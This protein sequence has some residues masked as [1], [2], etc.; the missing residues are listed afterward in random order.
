MKRSLLVTVSLVLLALGGYANGFLP[1]VPS[2]NTESAEVNAAVGD[3]MCVK[4]TR[5]VT[6]MASTLNEARLGALAA[7]SQQC[8][9]TALDAT[10]TTCAWQGHAFEIGDAGAYQCEVRAACEVCSS[11]D[12]SVN[13]K[14]F[15]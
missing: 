2:A 6:H 1:G 4:Q 13:E 8:P 10:R 11:A 3:S 15:E 14:V 5:A 12:M 9:R 7:W